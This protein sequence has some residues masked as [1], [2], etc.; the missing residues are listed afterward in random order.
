MRSFCGNPDVHEEHDWPA[1]PTA[2]FVWHCLGVHQHP[3][4][5]LTYQWDELEE[6]AVLVDAR[7]GEA[8]LR[9]TPSWVMLNS[10]R[11][12]LREA[13]HQL[14]PTGY[15]SPMLQVVSE[16]LRLQRW[17][18]EALE[19]IGR[20][21]RTHALLEEHGILGRRPLGASMADAVYDFVQRVLTD[22]WNPAEP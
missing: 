12:S 6:L 14:R 4:A 1:Q 18:S 3:F 13:Q 15:P 20:W 17:K 8:Y 2:G 10:L 7:L 19:V 22:G 9:N 21:E 11:T 16:M 5:T